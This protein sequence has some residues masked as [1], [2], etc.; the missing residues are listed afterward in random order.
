MR[1]DH[2]HINKRQVVHGG[3]LVSL[4]D[5]TLAV[6]CWNA[7]GGGPCATI[8][9]NTEFLGPARDGD[10]LVARAEVTRLTRSLVFVKGQL[11]AGDNLV[12]TANGVWKRL[13][14]D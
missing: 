6:A 12:L 8:T 2:R 10:W 13:G 11:F 4:I 14:A 3:M 1:A 7:G 5:T 9:L